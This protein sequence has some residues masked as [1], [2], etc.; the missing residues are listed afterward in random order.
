[1]GAPSSSV[2]GLGFAFGFFPVLR[3]VQ[4]TFSL[5]AYCFQPACL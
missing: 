4:M 1:M 2:V 3:Q 5:S